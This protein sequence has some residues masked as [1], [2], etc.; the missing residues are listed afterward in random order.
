[1]IKLP[2][3]VDDIV[4]N[5]LRLANTKLPEDIGW[6]LEAAA[7]WET[8]EIAYTQ[9]GAIMDNVKKAEH[10]GRPMCQDTGIPVF[11]V[12]GKFDSG[13]AKLI[14]KGVERATREIP[15]R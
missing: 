14:E 4:V 13:I 1:M 11:Y 6:A 15:L 9:L 2:E 3:P 12:R 5:L 7:G 10:I 8:N